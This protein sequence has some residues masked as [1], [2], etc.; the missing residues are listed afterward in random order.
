MPAIHWSCNEAKLD[1]IS[2]WML[3]D[4]KYSGILWNFDENRRN[5]DDPIYL[6]AHRRFIESIDGLLFSK[7]III[8]DIF[9]NLY[10]LNLCWFIVDPSKFWQ[11]NHFLAIQCKSFNQR[12]LLS[13]SSFQILTKCTTLLYVKKKYF[14]DEM[15]N[16][17]K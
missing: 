14:F 3:K 16:S 17:S 13:S 8:G 7:W 12:T 10:E 1:V 2:A 11:Y 9:K 15:K 4:E 5:F 6:F